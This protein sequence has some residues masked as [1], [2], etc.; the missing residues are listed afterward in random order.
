[1]GNAA[2]A[3]QTYQAGLKNVDPI[4]SIVAGMQMRQAFQRIDLAQE[5]SRREDMF[6]FAKLGL[7]RE[8]QATRTALAQEQ[9]KIAQFNAQTNRMN[10]ERA[11][12]KSKAGDGTGMN[13]WSALKSDENGLY[14]DP[15]ALAGAS[16]PDPSAANV[17]PLPAGDG[18]SGTPRVLPDSAA[19]ALPLPAGGAPSALAAS[20]LLPSP[21]GAA[22]TP[23]AVSEPAAPIS[24][25]RP[26]GGKLRLGG[27]T[28]NSKGQPSLSF[29]AEDAKDAPNP[30]VTPEFL[31]GMNEKYKHLGG[32]FV[33]DID[34]KGKLSYAWQKSDT[35][36]GDFSI[37][38]LPEKVQTSFLDDVTKMI[39]AGAEIENPSDTAKMQAAGI[40]PKDKNAAKMMLEKGLWDSSYAAAK[41]EKENELLGTASTYAKKWNAQM[42][43]KPG[44]VPKSGLDVLRDIGITSV[45]PEQ[46]S[47]LAAPAGRG[48]GAVTATAPAGAPSS[49]PSAA[50]PNAAPAGQQ[51]APST[52]ATAP[53]KS[54]GPAG[55]TP[56]SAS[57]QIQTLEREIA[58]ETDPKVKRQKENFL[59]SLRQNQPAQPTAAAPKAA[60][61]DPWSMPAKSPEAP[62]KEDT[63]RRE[64]AVRSWEDS[65]A[66]VARALKS[67][68][69]ASEI[70]DLN[71]SDA[72]DDTAGRG[73]DRIVKQSR[74]LQE[75]KD[76]LGIVARDG[77]PLR[78]DSPIFIDHEGRTVRLSEIIQA[79]YQDPRF[80]ASTRDS[81]GSTQSKN[82]F[83]VSVGKPTEVK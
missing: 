82:A 63:A 17:V 81:A 65:K 5:A 75:H 50:R 24:A 64:V 10:A 51:A 26:T 11:V 32:A 72:P 15:S 8:D 59:A 66:K 13:I 68:L 44:F 57:T 23:A 61:Q 49:T 39:E 36:H 38:S 80:K 54:A 35:L 52:K 33:P 76:A 74:W 70:A 56:S 7:E 62:P 41:K 58:A 48:N 14:L 12:S 20:P 27:I 19:G 21:A 16:T 53:A 9:L 4:G 42:A 78:S 55:A 34:S 83:T 29:K 28:V 1:M 3:A 77:K 25:N 67:T 47:T 43:G 37:S 45:Q 73:S 30:P 71:Q 22:A 2:I 31:A 60:E 18:G 46:N 69:T 79:V 40:D 6:G